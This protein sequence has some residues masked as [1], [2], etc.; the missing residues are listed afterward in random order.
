MPLSPF[1]FGLCSYRLAHQLRNLL[2]TTLYV[3]VHI[4]GKANWSRQGARCRSVGLRVPTR[5]ALVDVYL[6]P[7]ASNEYA[8]GIRKANLTNEKGSFLRIDLRD[9]QPSSNA[10]AYKTKWCS[11]Y[12]KADTVK[13]TNQHPR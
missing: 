1:P 13:G 8:P 12:I 4:S 7:H 9:N 3:V 10:L 5:Y 6:R 11:L 2:E